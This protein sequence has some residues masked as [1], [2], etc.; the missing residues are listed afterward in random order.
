MTEPRQDD[1]TFLMFSTDLAPRLSHSVDQV[2]SAQPRTRSIRAIPVTVA[3]VGANHGVWRLA[4]AAGAACREVYA[5]EPDLARS[6]RSGTRG[7]A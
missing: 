4:A 5:A 6:L 1:P 7:G 2:L 3:S